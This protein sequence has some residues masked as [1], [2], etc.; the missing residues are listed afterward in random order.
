[1]TVVR[2]SRAIGSQ[3]GEEGN[4][5]DSKERIEGTD[6]SVFSSSQ[7]SEGGRRWPSTL[8]NEEKDS[9]FLSRGNGTLA[10]GLNRETPD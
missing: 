2:R 3:Y 10:P 5:E 1:M 4:L 6:A 9:E 8:S 7:F